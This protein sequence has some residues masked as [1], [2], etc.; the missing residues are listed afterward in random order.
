MVLSC[1][2][3]I[4]VS[5]YFKKGTRE[6]NANM[7]IFYSP[8]PKWIVAV[9]KDKK[10]IVNEDIEVSETAKVIL[11]MVQ[12]T[13]QKQQ[14]EIEALKEVNAQQVDYI[15]KQKLEYEKLWKE[16][17]ELFWKHENDKDLTNE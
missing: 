11:N 14:S 4:Y 8:D 6:M 17:M 2:V 10:L 13:I 5:P 3:D 9:T 15:S 12:D 1:F 16:H 7:P